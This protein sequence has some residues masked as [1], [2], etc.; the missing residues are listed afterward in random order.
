MTIKKPTDTEI[1][2][3]LFDLNDK[4]NAE[5]KTK[6]YT[7]KPYQRNVISIL[8][9][10]HYTKS[11]LQE[12]YKKIL[13]EGFFDVAFT[14]KETS[15]EFINNI[16]KVIGRKGMFYLKK[17]ELNNGKNVT[18]PGF[19]FMGFPVTGVIFEIRLF[20]KKIEK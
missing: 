17:V 1:L 2:T 4:L 3:I 20:K 7:L 14:K 16:D 5:K 12:N 13:N 8:S 18:I 9:S 19:N 6:K 10:Y 11:K 15:D